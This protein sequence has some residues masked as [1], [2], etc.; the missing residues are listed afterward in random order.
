M[1]IR[2]YIY[3]FFL[4][5][6]VSSNW[7]LWTETLS[8]SASIWRT[9]SVK[10]ERRDVLKLSV[11]LMT[12]HFSVYELCNR[13]CFSTTLGFY[14]FFFCWGNMFKDHSIWYWTFLL[15]RYVSVLGT[16]MIVKL[17][18]LQKRWFSSAWTKNCRWIS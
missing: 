14:I 10:K 3:T 16:P 7:W 4:H 2:A 5:A 15:P 13:W 1:I 8:S 9:V 12:I 11:K 18:A 17:S 6:H